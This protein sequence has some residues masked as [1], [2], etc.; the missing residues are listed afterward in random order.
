MTSTA[1]DPADIA[2][3]VERLRGFKTSDV[4]DEEIRKNLFE[5]ARNVAFTLESPGD[6]IQR[7][8]YTV[9]PH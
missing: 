8:A 7:I 6:S 4:Y 1:S 3:L 9:R 5:A 2:G